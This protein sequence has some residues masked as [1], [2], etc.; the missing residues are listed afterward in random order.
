MVD[1]KIKLGNVCKA[2]GFFGLARIKLCREVKVKV[3][4][5]CPSLCFVFYYLIFCFFISFL[6]P[7]LCNPM[8]CVACQGP[9]SMEF[10]RQE[11]YSGLPFPSPETFY[12]VL[13]K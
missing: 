7:S 8:D 6:C 9:L 12:K 5:S 10:S 3:A 4:Q 1:V 2:L 11:Y 13:I